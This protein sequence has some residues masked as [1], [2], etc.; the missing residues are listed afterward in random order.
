M[1]DGAV[2]FL[3]R[4][5]AQTRREAEGAS[6]AYGDAFAMHKARPVVMGEGFER[7]P[8]GVAQIEQGAVAL[9]GLVAD[10]HCGF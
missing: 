1:G 10:H 5:Q 3:M 9:F 4:A 8:E 7:V 2:R 6:H